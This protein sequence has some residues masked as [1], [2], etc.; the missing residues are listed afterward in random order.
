M[1]SSEFHAQ[2]YSDF[3]AMLST[4]PLPLLCRD[5]PLPQYPIKSQTVG[6]AKEH[7]D[8]PMGPDPDL[9]RHVQLLGPVEI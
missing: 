8:F 1:S 4:Q 7:K 2:S 6:E 3:Y 5:N 9:T